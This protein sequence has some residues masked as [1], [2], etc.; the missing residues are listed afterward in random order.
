[1]KNHFFTIVGIAIV[2]SIGCLYYDSLKPSQNVNEPMPAASASENPS[3]AADIPDE[4]SEQDNSVI[5]QETSDNSDNKVTPA[6][7]DEQLIAYEKRLAALL[8][9]ESAGRKDIVWRKFLK[10]T[11]KNAEIHKK[12]LREY[13]DFLKVPRNR[14]I[15]APALRQLDLFFDL[16]TF[17]LSEEDRKLL[18]END[19]MREHAFEYMADLDP[20]WC[21]IY[22]GDTCSNTKEYTGGRDNLPERYRAYWDDIK[23]GRNENATAITALSHIVYNSYDYNRGKKLSHQVLKAIE[24]SGINVKGK[25]IAD[26]GAGSGMALPFFREA[27]GDGVKL[28]GVD[29]DPYTLDLLKFTAK[30]ADADVVDCT[31]SD[32]CLPEE[33]VDIIVLLG[34]HMGSG[35]HEHYEK[36][37][38]PWMKSMWKALRPGGIIVIHEGNMELLDEGLVK[39]MES[40]GFKLRKM[41]PPVTEETHCYEDQR[42]EF[43]AVF[44]K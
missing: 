1:M 28:Y 38:L 29:L 43:I 18:P 21:L 16:D 44:D 9:E 23:N 7:F 15:V 17:E 42:D 35:F 5:A 10:G 2:L 14:S 24:D 40:I 33:S 26:V 25:I 6:N 36:E 31:Y 13:L 3:P 4:K 12:F 11:G 20:I 37:T 19:E 30:F 34:V 32:C 27:A 39:R 22:A 41:F 8:R